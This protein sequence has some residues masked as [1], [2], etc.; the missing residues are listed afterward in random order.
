MTEDNLTPGAEGCKWRLAAFED[1][2]FWRAVEV[3]FHVRELARLLREEARSR[4]ATLASASASA[5]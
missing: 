1:D 3:R 5:S 4:A 2:R